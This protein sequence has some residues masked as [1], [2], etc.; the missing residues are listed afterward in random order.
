M[1]SVGH[2]GWREG[3]VGGVRVEGGKGEGT[4]RERQRVGR[5]G[6]CGGGGEGRWEDEVCVHMWVAGM[7]MH[8][9]RVS[10]YNMVYCGILR[11][12]VVYCDILWYTVIYC[13]ILWYTVVYCGILW[14]TVIYCDI[15]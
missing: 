8:T 13:G 6:G 4:K 3:R 2:E 14:Y 10:Y 11:Y 12:T 7:C 15:L 5:R 1:Q 9:L